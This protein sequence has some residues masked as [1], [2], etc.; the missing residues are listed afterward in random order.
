MRTVIAF[1]AGGGS[2]LESLLWTACAGV[3]ADPAIRLVWV[4]PD[5]TLARL[6]ELMQV[7]DRLRP[8]LAAAGA[9]GFITELSLET[10]TVPDGCAREMGGDALRQALLDRQEAAA[11]WRSRADM[12][13][14]LAAL[15]YGAAWR[16]G[17]WIDLLAVL[18]SEVILCGE[19]ADGW[20]ATG[21]MYLARRLAAAGQPPRGVWLTPHQAAKP[22]QLAV[23][24]ETLRQISEDNPFRGLHV[25]GMPPGHETDKPGIHLVH[26]LGALAAAGEADDDGIYT[27]CAQADGFAWADFGVLENEVQQGFEGLLKT[28]AAV[29]GE[30]LPVLRERL[31]VKPKLTQRRVGWFS[32]Y[33]RQSHKSEEKVL[34]ALRDQADALQTCMAGY[35][36]WTL[37][38]VASLP[39]QWQD[40][41][42]FE[43]AEQSMAEHYRQLLDVSGE[44]AMMNE[45]IV[46]SGMAEEKLVRR[47]PTED[48][49][50][51]EL[52]RRAASFREK[53]K[54]LESEQA[55]LDSV[56]GTGA[57]RRLMERMAQGIDRALELEADRAD[58]WRRASVRAKK[59]E[60]MLRAQENA[61]R[62]ENHM[63]VLEAERARVQAD[64][65]ALKVD[66]PPRL[67]HVRPWGNDLFDPAWLGML[68]QMMITED[69][70]A[71]REQGAAMLQATGLQAVLDGLGKGALKEAADPLG[72]LLARLME[73]VR[74]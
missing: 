20:C 14:N 71:R 4:E 59:G 63:R 73:E 47:S 45:E 42:A 26:W 37:E 34:E 11:M 49:A 31:G 54:Q 10:V 64:Q 32:G 24:G 55:A 29:Q 35:I 62:L 22:G 2:V 8:A 72:S 65:L 43:E 6:T 41:P 61:H 70:S 21:M 18:E 66:H 36:R 57:K 68:A 40:R 28:A 5:G 16:E 56:A 74:A 1:G 13:P 69:E 46:R 3:T 33:F 12:H 48:T 17:A 30:I 52:L 9:H 60:E 23:A 19:A 58:A 50:A 27:M 39:Q 38:M 53:V 67:P 25:I 7:Y 44:L 51:D 15:A